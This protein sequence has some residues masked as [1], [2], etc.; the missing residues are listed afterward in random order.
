MFASD[1]MKPE[2]IAAKQVEQPGSLPHTIIK[3]EI[4]MKP[5]PGLHQMILSVKIPLISL[6]HRRKSGRKTRKDSGASA[7]TTVVKPRKKR[8]QAGH[9]TSYRNPSPQLDDDFD[10]SKPDKGPKY[11]KQPRKNKANA[12][13]AKK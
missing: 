3:P 2:Q 13:K 5:I 10:E 6:V 8:K 4:P 11:F 12:S 1:A 9:E 7:T